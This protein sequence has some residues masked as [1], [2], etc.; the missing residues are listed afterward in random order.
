MTCFA[1]LNR[2]K[3]RMSSHDQPSAGKVFFK[4]FGCQMNEYDSGKMRAML[5]KDGWQVT[6]DADADLVIVNTCSIREKAVDKL[7]S[8]LG[9]FRR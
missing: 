4:T 2:L 6:T 9:D 1:T 8:Y 5:G 7:H 3:R